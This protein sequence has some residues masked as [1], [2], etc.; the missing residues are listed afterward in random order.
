MKPLTLA[1][2]VVVLLS[3]AAAGA[4]PVAPPAGPGPAASASEPV[5]TSAGDTAA[6]D[7]AASDPA[8][9]DP[10]ASDPA[11][12]SDTAPSDAIAT[13]APSS[14][15]AELSSPEATT[16]DW[17]ELSADARAADA[18]NPRWSRDGHD[19]GFIVAGSIILVA[20]YLLAAIPI[21]YL[22]AG[23]RRAFFDDALDVPHWWTSFIPLMPYLT[24]IDSTSSPFLFSLPSSIG[25]G[26]G[27]GLLLAGLFAHLDEVQVGQASLRF[28]GRAAGADAEE[29]GLGNG[30]HARHPVHQGE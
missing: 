29:H 2:L 30:E 25:Q 22:W 26:I 9:S 18:H 21:P 7:P 1:L 10:A 16:F 19:D 14:S 11:A 6:D 20:S 5:G 17:P 3:P 24:Q 8:A 13:P 12:A 4:Q 27:L 15:A 23:A 28:S